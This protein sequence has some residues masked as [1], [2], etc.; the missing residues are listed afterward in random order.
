[1]RAGFEAI[2]A[3]M[4]VRAR[5]SRSCIVPFSGT[6]IMVTPWRAL[7]WQVI[8]AW[9]SRARLRSSL[10]TAAPGTPAQSL[11]RIRSGII[12]STC[13]M[14]R[15]SLTRGAAALAAVLSLVGFGSRFIALAL[16]VFRESRMIAQLEARRALTA[17]SGASRGGPAAN[18]PTENNVAGATP[19]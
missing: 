19:A 4:A 3:A 17:R 18:Q 5:A 8:G 16:T 2:A 1:M 10:S 14:V 15:R 13:S 7:T 6:E 12:T 11:A 9:R